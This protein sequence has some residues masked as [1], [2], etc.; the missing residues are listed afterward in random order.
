MATRSQRPCVAGIGSVLQSFSDASAVAQKHATTAR[1]I[2]RRGAWTN[3]D[4]SPTFCCGRGSARLHALATNVGE[5]SGLN[6]PV[7]AY[8]DSPGSETTQALAVFAAGFAALTPRE[9]AAAVQPKIKKLRFCSMGAGGK[10]PPA[11]D[12]RV[13]PADG[14]ARRSNIYDI[15]PTRGCSIINSPPSRSEFS[16]K[17]H[18]SFYPASFGT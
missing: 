5:I 6:V 12:R 11:F 1:R 2:N 4:I 3:P 18:G 13:I 7:G 15:L 16:C 17:A 9:Q 8:Q 14:V 10:S